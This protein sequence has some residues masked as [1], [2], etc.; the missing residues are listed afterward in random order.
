MQLYQSVNYAY[1]YL[2]GRPMTKLFNWNVEDCECWKIYTCLHL[3]AYL[4][5]KTIMSNIAAYQCSDGVAAIAL[6]YS[7]FS[8]TSSPWV[9]MFT[10]LLY[11]WGRHSC[12]PDMPNLVISITWRVE[13]L[14]ISRKKD[15][16]IL[17]LQFC[18]QKVT[19]HCISGDI[20]NYLLYLL[21]IILA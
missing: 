1:E 14:V 13:R 12:H 6:F 19:R 11:P 10:A 3:K 8:H 20:N 18:S 16:I 17:Y 5:P 21:K 7:L 4:N 15:N 9:A 2:E